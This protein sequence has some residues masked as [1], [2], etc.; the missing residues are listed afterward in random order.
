MVEELLVLSWREVFQTANGHES[1]RRTTRR[2]SA[3][4]FQ[5]W[6]R[7]VCGALVFFRGDN[8]FGVAVAGL[9]SGDLMVE[10]DFV[11]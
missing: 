4:S 9:P 7:G 6:H 2:G 8:S 10:T 5:D 3:R 11:K 1:S